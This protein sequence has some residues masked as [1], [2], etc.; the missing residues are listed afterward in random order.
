MR[1]K[2]KFCEQES[3]RRIQLFLMHHEMERQAGEVVPYTITEKGEQNKHSSCP[4]L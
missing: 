3:R 4:S 1:K 2:K